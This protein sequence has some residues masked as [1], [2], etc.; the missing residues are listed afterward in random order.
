MTYSQLANQL[1]TSEQHVTDSTSSLPAHLN[2][3]PYLSF[4]VCTGSSRPTDEEFNKLS[5]ALGISNV[6]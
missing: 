5:G 3:N 1:G 2:C 6:S 4:I